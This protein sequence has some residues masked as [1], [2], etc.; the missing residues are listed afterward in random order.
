MRS[1][2]KWLAPLGSSLLLAA[3]LFAFSP[4]ADPNQKAANE[5]QL[6]PLLD[7]LTELSQFIERNSQSPQIWQYH[8]EQAEVLLR[9]ATQSQEKEREGVLRMAVDAFYS[10]ALLCPRE[11]P[12]AFERLRQLP[13]RLAQMFPGSS[14]ILYAV[15][16]EIQADCVLVLEQ[17]GGDSVKSEKHRCERLMHFA[18]E[19]PDVPEA[20]KAILQAAQTAESIGENDEAGRCYRYLIDHFPTDPGT[21]KAVG[22]LWRLGQDHQPMVL[23]LPLLYTSANI[24]NAVFNLDE[25]R[26]RLVIV[27]FWTST[28][29]RVSEEF[30]AL[31][32]LTDR[33]A[34][35]GLQIVYVNMNSDPAEGRVFLS[36]RLTAGV[37]VYQPGGL[38]GAIAERYGLQKVPQAFLVGTDG[39]LLKHSLSAEQLATELS[40]RL[41]SGR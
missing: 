32:Q 7:K 6:R 24:S 15:L 33:Y 35:R 19:H 14:A 8:L 17:S 9:L 11:Q 26:G 36:G 12:T 29:E 13:G 1:P 5:Q 4:D 34:G 2:W 16:Q 41:P 25:M 20:A 27:Y 22:A 30:Q 18:R 23:E 37:H 3:N 21:R 38:E 40:N 39:E 31:K 10:S 28:G